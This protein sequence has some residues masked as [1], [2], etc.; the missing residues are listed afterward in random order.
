MAG[1]QGKKQAQL[2]QMITN[3]ISANQVIDVAID[4]K[5]LDI[6]CKT[7]PNVL[8]AIVDKIC[9]DEADYSTLDF[10][11]VESASSLTGVLQNIL[12]A[13]TCDEGGSGGQTTPNNL[14][15]TGL[16]PCTTDNWNCSNT[17][18]CFDLGNVCDPGVV[19]VKLALQKLIN[20]NVAYGNVIKSLCSQISD[21]QQ[22]I[23]VINLTVTNIQTSCC[24]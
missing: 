13:I 8:Q 4:D 14:E 12:N 22:Q 2:L 19:T 21:L 11:C 3:P 20:R 17:D 16:T 15:I 9:E 1:K 7:L 5:C 10:G 6:T 18:A 24:P 23:N